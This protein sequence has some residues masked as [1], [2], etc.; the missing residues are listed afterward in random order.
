MKNPNQTE[1]ALP[2]VTI[3]TVTY[4]A[5]ALL[6]KTLHNLAAQ[7]YD[8]KEV[9]VVDGKSADD[10]MD[11]VRRHAADITTWV[12]E[13]DRGI[14]DAMNKGVRM[15]TGEWVIFMNAGDVFAS[16]DVLQ[17]V[18]ATGQPIEADVVYGDVVKDGQVKKAPASYHLYHRMLFCHQCVF[19][20]RRCLLDTPFDITHRL[21]AD[22][23]FFIV[24]Y[25]RN[26]RFQ[27]LDFPVAVFDTGGVS[28]RRR[29]KGLLDNIRV[30]CETIPFPQ[31]VQFVARLAVPY[32]MC[33]L[34]GK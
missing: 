28:N 25:Q 1:L 7:Q 26:A 5:G 11:I 15:A 18:F 23:K 20:R 8:N 29:S 6:E 2:K 24:Q 30:V 27:Y 19:V 22:F 16:D 10:T 4:N 21:S 32:V 3:V 33:R 9:V 31:R 14:Y 17:R 12:S 34:R 13:P